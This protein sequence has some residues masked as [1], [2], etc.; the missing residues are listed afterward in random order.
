MADT[1]LKYYNSDTTIP[2]RGGEYW[3]VIYQDA[4]R[5]GVY[6][7][8]LPTLRRIFVFVLPN[9]LDKNEENNFL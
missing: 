1:L 5:R 4:K 2:R 8:L 3:C 7:A 9:Q 6:L